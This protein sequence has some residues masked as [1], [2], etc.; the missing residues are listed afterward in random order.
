MWERWGSECDSVSERE[1]CFCCKS[2]CILSLDSMELC[3]F[4][5]SL[6]LS[7]KFKCQTICHLCQHQ[8]PCQIYNNGSIKCILSY[9]KW[10][11]NGTKLVILGYLGFFNSLRI[12]IIAVLPSLRFIFLADVLQ[13]C[14]IAVL[15][16]L[17]SSKVEFNQFK[18]DYSNFFFRIEANLRKRILEY[19]ESINLRALLNN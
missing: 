10:K 5:V 6:C 1:T 17:F 15:F 16:I 14:F 2:V 13:C 18:N 19:S 4:N 7:V 12:L 8:C 9:L 11:S 3:M